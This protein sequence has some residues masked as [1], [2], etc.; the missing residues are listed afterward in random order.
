MSTLE[1]QLLETW[2]IHNRVHLYVLDTLAP[3]ALADVGANKGRSVGEQFAH[4]HNVRLLWLESAA[5]ALMAGLAKIEKADAGDQ[6]GLRQALDDSGRAIATLVEQA[7]AAGG[8]V[9]GFKPHAAAFVG[10]LIAHE[11][12]HRGEIGLILA[13]AGHPLDKKTAYGMW[14][15]GVR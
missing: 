15:W 5:P 8:R 3:E 14:E 6:D 11:S 2:A 4:I 9:K 13:H 12:Y 10:Y 7:L 1:E